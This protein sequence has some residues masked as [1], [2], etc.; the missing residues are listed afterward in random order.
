[1][2]PPAAL[3]SNLPEDCFLYFYFLLATSPEDS[4]QDSLARSGRR[5]FRVKDVLNTLHGQQLHAHPR[6]ATVC[7]VR[8]RALKLADACVHNLFDCT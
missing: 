4:M 6:A 3:Y 2:N 8:G 7:F 5:G 1:M